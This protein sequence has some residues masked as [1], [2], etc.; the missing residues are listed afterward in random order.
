MGVLYP[1]S[2]S[3]VRAG[4][5]QPADVWFLQECVAYGPYT[6][7]AIPIPFQKLWRM[8]MSDLSGYVH[9]H[10]EREAVRLSDQA[11]TLAEILHH[12][13]AYPAGSVVLEAG[14]GVGAQTGILLSRS[15]GARIVSLDLSLS[16][17]SCA[18][19]S[20]ASRG[21]E[22]IMFARGDLHSLPFR[23]DSFDHVFV[24]FVLEHLKAPLR[25]LKS[26]QRILKP[27]GT[28]TVIEGDHGSAF[29]HPQSRYATEAILALE[30]LQRDAG[31]NPRIGRELFP[32]LNTAGFR[33]VRVSPRQVYVDDSKPLL[34]EGFTRQTFTA[35]VEGVREKVITNG[36]LAEEDFD[37]GIRDLYRTSEGGG[38]FCYTFFKAV[39]VR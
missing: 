19:G 31:G 23:E 18:R 1:A 3:Q 25:A 33:D 5:Y 6:E 21:W 26:L 9:G 8:T 30:R 36:M 7:T 15:R 28:L 34:V 32:L 17:L 20:A 11:G 14:C 4:G 10:S 22:E 16:S 24:C 2:L 12:D 35:M 13:T 37:R 29:F 38:T 39:A 27:G